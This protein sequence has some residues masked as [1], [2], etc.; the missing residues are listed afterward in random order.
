MAN[1]ETE[2][3]SDNEVITPPLK[4]RRY[5]TRERKK[6]PLFSDEYENTIKIR[7]LLSIMKTGK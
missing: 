1:S 2:G 6:N 5:P 7:L 4:E 3:A